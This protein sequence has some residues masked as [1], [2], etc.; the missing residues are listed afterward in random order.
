MQDGIST[1]IVFTFWIVTIQ[2]KKPF[3]YML[4]DKKLW[5]LFYLIMF[6]DMVLILCMATFVEATARCEISLIIVFL[7]FFL[8]YKK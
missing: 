5:L 6:I 3:K 7:K 8:Y 1:D 2:I 4:K